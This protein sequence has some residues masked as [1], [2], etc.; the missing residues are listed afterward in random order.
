MHNTRMKKTSHYNFIHKADYAL[1]CV[2][3]FNGKIAFITIIVAE[4]STE[5][6]PSNFYRHQMKKRCGYKM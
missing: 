3:Q 2:N 6:D 4:F 5:T 1:S